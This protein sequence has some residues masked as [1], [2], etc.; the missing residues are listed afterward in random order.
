MGQKVSPAEPE[1]KAG[2]ASA[3]QGVV[4]LDGPNGVAISMTV[5]AA[6]GTAHSLLAAAEEAM[7]Q[8][9]GETHPG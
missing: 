3:E 5:E 2:I 9:G 7:G 1:R 6:Q 4:L 8:R